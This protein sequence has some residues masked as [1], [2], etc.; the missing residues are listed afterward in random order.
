[1][2]SFGKENMEKG[3][4][5]RRIEGMNI[6]KYANIHETYSGFRNFP[7]P[8][9]AQFLP[10]FTLI[11]HKYIIK[12]RTPSTSYFTQKLRKFLCTFNKDAGPFE[13]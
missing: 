4:L 13:T 6:E 9:K 5:F 12:F 1:M 10:V 11:P 2:F 3:T 7:K 8:K